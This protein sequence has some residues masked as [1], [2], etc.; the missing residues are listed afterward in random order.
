MKVDKDTCLF[1]LLTRVGR[2]REWRRVGREGMKLT[3]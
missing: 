2:E 3:K 1:N